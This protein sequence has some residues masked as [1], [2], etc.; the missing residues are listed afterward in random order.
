MSRL[1]GR[2][3]LLV[4]LEEAAINGETVLLYGPLGIGKT[5]VLAELRRRLVKHGLPCGFAPDSRH[6]GEVTAALVSAYP[7]IDAQAFSQKRLRSRL[8]LTVENKP[9]VLLLDRFETAGTAMKSF[10]RSLRRTRTAVV[11]ATDVENERD[12]ALTRAQNMTHIEV[13]V[14]PLPRSAMAAL[15]DD[16][17]GSTELPHPLHSE[18]RKSLLRLAQG[19]PGRLVTFVGLLSS[20]RFWRGDRTRAASIGIEEIS[21]RSNAFPTTASAAAAGPRP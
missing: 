21:R 19:N 4:Q 17:L 20:S 13:E 9:G 2:E 7:S 14:P 11:L 3:K 6:L 10:L 18:D 1:F 15:M 16:L 5:S 8:R 12:H